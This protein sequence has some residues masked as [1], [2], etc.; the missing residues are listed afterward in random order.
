M[1]CD[2]T[3]IGSQGYCVLQFDVT[4]PLSAT[5]RIDIIV[6][7]EMSISSSAT[8]LYISP[9]NDLSITVIPA[10]SGSVITLDNIVFS[11]AQ[12]AGS[13]TIEVYL[14]TFTLPPSLAKTSSFG[15][16]TYIN[17]YK[18]DEKL[19]GLYF[20]ATTGGDMLVNSLSA[21]NTV[22]GQTTSYSFDLSLTSA[23]SASGGVY[24]QF[25]SSLSLSSTCSLSLVSSN[26]D[27]ISP[28]CTSDTTKNAVTLSNLFSTGLSSKQGISFTVSGIRN[29]QTTEPTS[30][31]TIS[32]LYTSSDSTSKMDQNTITTVTFITAGALDLSSIIMTPTSQI[33]SDTTLYTFGFTN[34]NPCPSGGTLTITIPLANSIYISSLTNTQATLSSSSNINPSAVVAISQTTSAYT[35]KIPNAFSSNYVSGTTFKFSLNYIKNPET[36]QPVPNIIFSTY[37]STGYIIDTLSTGFTFQVTTPNAFTSSNAIAQTLVNG[38][39]GSYEYDLTLSVNHY[40]NDVISIVFPSQISSS[41]TTY[42]LLSGSAPTVAI[43]NFIKSGST[44]SFTLTTTATSIVA[45]SK[46]M[47]SVGSFTNSDFSATLGAFTFSSISSAGYSRSKSTLTNSLLVLTPALLTVPLTNMASSSYIL[48]DTN[49]VYTFKLQRINYLEAGGSITVTFPTEITAPSSPTCTDIAGITAIGC[50]TDTT[51]NKVTVTG[52]YAS[53]PTNLQFTIAFVTNPSTSPS[54]PFIIATK[55]SAGAIIDQIA[56]DIRFNA[57]CDIPCKTCSITDRSSC[58]SCFTDTSSLL[59]YL[60]SSTCVSTCPAG[61]FTQVTTC[62]ACD[63]GCTACSGS[64]TNCLAC[65]SSPIQ[66]Y[67]YGTSCLSSCPAKYYKDSSTYTCKSCSAACDTCSDYSTCTSC[68]SSTR[69]YSGT[70]VSP[71]PTGITIDTGTTCQV[72]SS[73]CATCSSTTTYCTSCTNTALIV[74]NGQ[75]ITGCPAKMYNDPTAHTCMQC[76]T[77]CQNCIT[78]STTC[79]SCNSGTYLLGTSCLGVCSAGYYPDATTNQCK[80]CSDGCAACTSA[81]ICYQCSS[82]TYLYSGS[83]VTSCPKGTTLSGQTCLDC[84]K[85]C[86]TCSSS[87]SNCLSC[88]SGYKLS[89]DG[90]CEKTQASQS[91][92]IPF[93]FIIFTFAV[94]LAIIACKASS[95]KTRLTSNLLACITLIFYLAATALMIFMLMDTK[96]NIIFKISNIEMLLVIGGLL[97]NYFNNLVYLVLGFRLM[98]KDVSFKQWKQNK[99]NSRC[100]NTILVFSLMFTFSLCR[101]VYSRLLGLHYFSATIKEVGCIKAVRYITLWNIFTSMLPIAGGA[102]YHLRNGYS[103]HQLSIT[104][105]EVMI[106]VLVCWFLF[107]SEIWKSG[108]VHFE[109]DEIKKVHNAQFENLVTEENKSVL[110]LKKDPNKSSIGLLDDESRIDKST[111]YSP[112]INLFQSETKGKAD[113]SKTK[114]GSHKARGN[115]AEEDSETTVSG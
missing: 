33:T 89:S 108:D 84:I 22:A 29:P 83:C 110:H 9:D 46:I 26:I 66:Y 61:T 17:N 34:N 101:F 11:G 20:Q 95:S 42:I 24:I 39:S 25:P 41:V 75:C 100:S 97:M 99:V 80:L 53:I 63:I 85:G 18:V 73:E 52:T 5:A 113:K 23:V 106:L 37:T 36:T 59:Q 62:I 50:T 82:T 21:A 15:I 28:T 67:S 10:V 45:G 90:S 4:N 7:P 14:T 111:M 30:T 32:S 2:P 35:I 31:L 92:V 51:T 16:T 55:T 19:T 104:A 70:C 13:T 60:Y 96:F 56:T 40:N 1:I 69:L 48:S 105:I 91:T 109:N 74:Y 72:C 44:L 98:R 71:C 114:E 65:A 12:V 102:G 81:S 54:S 78:S 47:I 27:G 58:L 49:V 38:E 6:P 77:S 43:S 76:S 112:E 79:T 57:D 86:E 64:A 3:E 115:L 93:P 68:P 107:I 103:S 88:S 8:L 94:S 87:S